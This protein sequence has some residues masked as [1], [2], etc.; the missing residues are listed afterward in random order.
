MVIYANKRFGTKR[1]NEEFFPTQ[2]PGSTDFKSIEL[3]N[4]G[5]DY[6]RLYMRDALVQ[7]TMGENANLDWQAYQPVVV[8]LN[9]KYHALLNLRERSNEDNI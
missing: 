2:R 7:R 1:L 5:N 6:N 9:G 8:Y 3:R 4:S